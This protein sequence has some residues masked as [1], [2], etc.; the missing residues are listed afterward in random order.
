[1]LNPETIFYTLTIADI[2]SVAEQDYENTL[3]GNE[4]SDYDHSETHL[5]DEDIKALMEKIPDY[6]PWFD[7]I[8]RA[9]EDYRSEKQENPIA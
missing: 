5:S 3:S 8:E 1:M 2:H 6:I 9:I 4:P 7:C